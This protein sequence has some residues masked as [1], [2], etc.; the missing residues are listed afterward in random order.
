MIIIEPY[1]EYLIVG[2]F[3]FGYKYK[4]PD[5]PNRMTIIKSVETLEKQI[6]FTN[7]RELQIS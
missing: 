3:Q 5:Q 7:G 4:V 1:F 6:K 2:Y